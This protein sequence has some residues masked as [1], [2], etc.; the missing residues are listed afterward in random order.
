V[1]TTKAL[2]LARREGRLRRRERAAAAGAAAAEAPWSEISALVDETLAGLEEEPRALLVA[3]FLEGVTQDTL[4]RARGMSQ[5]TISR[6]LEEALAA[7][8][9]RL[10]G[11]GVAIGALAL[12][13]RLQAES[14]T[15]APPHVVAQLGRMALAPAATAATVPALLAAATTAMLTASLLIAL[16]QRGPAASPSPAPASPATPTKGPP[17]ADD[18]RIDQQLMLRAVAVVDAGDAAE[19]RRL[20]SAHPGLV[21]AR[22]ASDDGRYAGYFHH[23]TLLHHTAGNAMPPKPPPNVVE[24]AR[25]L[26]DAGAEVDARTDGGP[27]QP[28]D[29]GWTTLGLAAT[30]GDDGIGAN[31]DALIDLLVARG[32]DV[33]DANGLPMAGALFYRFERGWR[34]LLRHGARL[35]LRLAANVG[36]LERVRACFTTDGALKPKASFLSRYELDRPPSDDVGAVLTEALFSA[37]SAGGA[38]HTEIARLLIDRGA[39]VR[40]RIGGCT[41]LH[42]AAGTGDLDLVRLLLERGADPTVR[43]LQHQSTPAEWADYLHQEACARLLREAAAGR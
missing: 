11:R 42:C 16:L 20:L 19:L 23:A 12:A 31:A 26:L 30:A 17:V 36:D 35:D 34:A 21:H 1:A 33:D 39:D 27:A 38:P 8:R 6:R 29:P 18:D 14:A 32:A 15:T 41:A 9:S 22:V 13:D 40:A 25:I 37:C 7:L 2:D 43:D 5:A 24:I 3:H 28:N 4:A 10:R